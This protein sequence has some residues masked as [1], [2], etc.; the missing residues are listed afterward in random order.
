MIDPKKILESLQGNPAASG[1]LGGLAGSL[2]GNVLGGGRGIK[3][4][5]LLKA[6]TLAAVGYVAWQAWQRHQAQ[7]AGKP[8]AP[9]ANPIPLQSIPAAL[10]ASIPD[11]F[12][13]ARKPQNG[14]AI[15]QAMIA[16]SKADGVLDPAERD[17]IFD[18][19]NELNLTQEEHDYVLKMLTQP[20]DVEALLRSATSPEL[21]LELYT[22][23]AL[24]A[25]P[26]SRAERAWLDMLAARLGLDESLTKE[27]DRAVEGALVAR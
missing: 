17:R 20:A 2:L 11:A 13:L 19:V 14:L 7:Q 25:H 5:G 27:A 18:R 23:A 21:A 16:A 6:G 3:T 26:A 12:D 4:K 22:A 1:A 24:T 8:P 9:S 15:A 10:P